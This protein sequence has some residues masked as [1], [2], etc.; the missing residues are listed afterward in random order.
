MDY[1][2]ITKS[3]LV[4]DHGPVPG[5]GPDPGPGPSPGSKLV[6]VHGSGL[7]KFLVP[8]LVPVSSYFWSQPWSRS[9]SRSQFLIPS[10][11][12]KYLTKLQPFHP[13]KS[14]GLFW[15][16]LWLVWLFLWLVYIILGLVGPILELVGQI[17]GLGI[18]HIKYLSSWKSYY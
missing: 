14:K 12:E 2:L 4:L 15:P 11:S 17:L 1:F 9:Q 18:I 16:I 10:L 13:A 5:P 3:C 6:P 8:A 7:V